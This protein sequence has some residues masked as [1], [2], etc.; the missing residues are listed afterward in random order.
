[1]EASYRRPI[2]LFGGGESIAV[3]LF[4]TFTD[5]LSTTNAG[6][7][8]VDRVGQTGLGGGAP[9]WQANL[10]MN[11]ARGPLSIVA[12]ERFIGKGVYDATY[13]AADIDDNSIASAFY[14]NVRMSYDFSASNTDM[15]LYANVSN[16]FNEDPPLV[17]TW[18]FMGSTATNEGLFDV[19]G[20]RYTVGVRMNF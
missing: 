12:Q 15:T 7:P 19:L 20:R 4:T 2:E 17:G 5:E 14:T 18:G 6:A 16:L 9:R 10:A 1:M 11:Y 3:R 8:K 13:T